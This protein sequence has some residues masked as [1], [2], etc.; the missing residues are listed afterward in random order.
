MTCGRIAA[1]AHFRNM[2]IISVLLTKIRNRLLHYGKI[3]KECFLLFL[4]YPVAVLKLG[5]HNRIH[6]F[7][8]R[9][10][11]ARDNGFALFKY[12]RTVH[13]EIESY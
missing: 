11:D 13:P 2:N 1:Q 5:R 9:G 8:E 3:T 6:I 4:L 7:S 10:T 12:Y